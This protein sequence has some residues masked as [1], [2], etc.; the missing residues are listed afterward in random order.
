MVR[1]QVKKGRPVPSARPKRIT[2]TV[3][4]P[5]LFRIHGFTFV[6]LRGLYTGLKFSLWGFVLLAFMAL[7]CY[8]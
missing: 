1:T 6:I 7:C 8:L 5:W 2:V 3:E 4:E